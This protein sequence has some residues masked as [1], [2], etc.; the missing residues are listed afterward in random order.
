MSLDTIKEITLLI[1]TKN[2]TIFLKRV[3]SYYKKINFSGTLA[4]GDSSTGDYLIDNQK[5]YESMKGSI[6]MT[7]QTFP[8]KNL[9]QTSHELLKNVKTKFVAEVHDDN[10]LIPDSIGKCIEFLNNNSDYSAARGLGVSIKT[11][12]DKP[13]GGLIKC[14]KKKQPSSECDSSFVSQD[15]LIEQSEIVIIGAPHVEYSLIDFSSVK[16]INIWE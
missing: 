11:K 6:N 8:D 2:R 4:I 7:Y 9:C 1:P 5:I 12:N 13:Y 10:F 14:V 3:L 15:E 16:L